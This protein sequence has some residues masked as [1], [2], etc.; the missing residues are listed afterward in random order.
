MALSDI[1]QMALSD[2]R[3]VTILFKMLH[4]MSGK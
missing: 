1:R 2:K 4:L 3:Q